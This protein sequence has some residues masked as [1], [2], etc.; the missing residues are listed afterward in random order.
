VRRL[1]I[2]V[3][4][5][6]AVAATLAVVLGAVGA[7]VYARVQAQIDG[8][9]DGELREHVAAV[10][11]R[12]RRAD[13]EPRHGIDPLNAPGPDGTQVLDPARRVVRSTASAGPRALLGAATLRRA[14]AARRLAPV[15]Q[16]SRRV[17]VSAGRF[18][19]RE[20]VIVASSPLAQRNHALDRLAEQLIIGGLAGLLAAALAAYLIAR[21]AFRPFETMRRQA[22]AISAA[23]PGGRLEIPRSDDELARL[24][25]TLNEMLERLQRALEHERRFV[26]EASHELRTPLAVL[27]AELE[28]AR[29]RPR[30]REELEAALD[31]VAE[32]ADRLTRLADDLLLLAR[33]DEGALEQRDE[34]EVADLLDGVAAV[35]AARAR[36]LGRTIEVD[37]PRGVAVA[38]DAA[39]LHRALTNLVDNALRH[40]AGTVRLR[41]AAD[42][43]RVGV[44][45][46]DEGEGFPPGFLPVAFE[47]FSRAGRAPDGTG[48][49]LALVRAVAEA[50]GGAADAGAS[51]DGGAEVWLSLPRAATPQRTGV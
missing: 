23:E 9:I 38:G 4:L 28:L 7:F 26:A 33:A 45:V 20:L 39:A 8:Q 2:R 42:D 44:H 5:A 24:G 17:L 36:A 40:G 14:L 16:G 46:N 35:F 29:S 21:R 3:R 13:P 43:G 30:P 50:H 48:L 34:V 18:R 10:A 41:A 22:A 12:L 32:E 19:G 49:G 31:S 51:P 15:H 25:R 6:L 1:S 27:R 37:A 47:R 11:D